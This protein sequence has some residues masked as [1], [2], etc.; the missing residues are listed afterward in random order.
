M[1][2]SPI[3]AA[4]RAAGY[5]KY[6]KVKHS[7]VVHSDRTGVTLRPEA[8][9]AVARMYPEFASKLPGAPTKRPRKENR[10]KPNALRCRLDTPQFLMVYR[11]MTEDGYDTQQAFLEECIRCY[12]VVNG[13]DWM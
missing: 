7:S 12:G 3:I 10:Q 9:E 5:P 1:T 13:K 2:A 8:L 4:V 11:W 6:D